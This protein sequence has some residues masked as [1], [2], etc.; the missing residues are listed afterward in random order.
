MR[1]V[2]HV[3]RPA[4]RHQAS[5]PLDCLTPQERAVYDVLASHPGRVLSRNELARGAGLTDMNP[6]RC[7]ALLVG[8]RRA[9]GADGVVTVRR[10]GW[11]LVA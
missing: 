11:M 10:R 9:V 8:V 3:G 4:P 7:D 5:S 6:R 1:T 2:T